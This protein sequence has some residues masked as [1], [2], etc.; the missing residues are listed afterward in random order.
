M[1]RNEVLYGRTVNGR[2][3]VGFFTA[4]ENEAMA[5][6]F[7]KHFMKITEDMGFKVKEEKGRLDKES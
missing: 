6:T 7:R 1:E 2:G 5:K 3:G 4:F